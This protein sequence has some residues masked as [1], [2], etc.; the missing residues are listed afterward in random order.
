MRDESDV[1]ALR[2][3]IHFA[4]TPYVRVRAEPDGSDRVTVSI[5][6][7]VVFDVPAA[8]YNFPFLIDYGT[9]D[10]D[11][12][13]KTFRSRW[14]A[15]RGNGKQP[16]IVPTSVTLPR[17]IGGKIAVRLVDIFGNDA[18]ALVTVATADAL[19]PVTAARSVRRTTGTR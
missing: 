5:E 9:I 15:F 4:E 17:G 18:S 12:D 16:K 13:G 6:R 10:P 1:E 3:K 11:Y 8:K 7:Y 14:Q 2:P 19:G